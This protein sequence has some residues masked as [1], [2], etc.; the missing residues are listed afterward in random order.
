M[1]HHVPHLHRSYSALRLPFSPSASTVVP[2]AFGLPRDGFFF[3]TEARVHPLSLASLGDLRLPGPRAARTPAGSW[4]KMG[5]PGFW[6]ILSLR[7]AIHKPRHS[8][9]HLSH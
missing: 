9:R 8:L 1:C 2:L 7:A 4:R 3:L 5:L 6:T